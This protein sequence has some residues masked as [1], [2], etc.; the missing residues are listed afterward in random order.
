MTAL[1]YR[2]ATESDRAFVVDSLVSSFR[3]AHAAGL[4]AMDDWRDVM[5]RQVVK[6]LERPGVVV[7]VACRPGE[8]DTGADVYGWIAV[9]QGEPP[10]VLYC[11]VKQPYRRL[12]MA[13]GLFRAAGVDPAQPFEFAA[14]TAVVSKL[15]G[16]IPRAKWHPLR[17]R[18]TPKT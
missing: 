8:E 10:L 4:I 9:E 1:A 14:K 17:A 11:Y 5:E 3:T 13:R 6:L 7:T 16:K 18:F 15:L 2:S 12:G